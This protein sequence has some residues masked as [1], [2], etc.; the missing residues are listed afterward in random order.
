MNLTNKQI[1]AKARF[2]LDENVF[3]R[4]WMKSVVIMF[5]MTLIVSS[6]GGVLYSLSNVYLLPFLMSTFGGLSPV[7]R[8][9]IP[10]VLEILEVLMLNIF[11][12][13]LAVGMASVHLD[14]VRGDGRI[15]IR[16][17][18]EGFKGFF[19]NFLIGFMYTLH[20]TL[21]SLLLIVP[22]IYVAYSYALVFHVKKDNPSFRWQ[23]CVD[24]SE[25]LMQGNRWRL[26][27]LQCSFIGWT[28]LGL[29]LFFPFGALW[30]GP[31]S[32]TATALFYEQVRLEKDS[33]VVNFETSIVNG[34]DPI[35]ANN[36]KSVK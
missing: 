36:T 10:I 5:L 30:V 9:V 7:L 14:L 25:R 4:D 31:Y 20:I 11:L 19:D 23:Q 16:K 2:L 34:T 1:R 28:F 33:N 22:G 6:T 18:F 35:I 17:F 24:E 29:I 8:I 21:W 27:K 32:Q 26:F 12:G 13:P 15:R 3:G